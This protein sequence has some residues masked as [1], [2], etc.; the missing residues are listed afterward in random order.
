MERPALLV[1]GGAGT[2]PDELVDA[3]CAS[4]EA[5]A[6]AGWLVL[7]NGGSALDAVEAAVQIMEDDPAPDAGR[8]SHLNRDG[9][10]EMDAIIMDGASLNAG[11]VAGITRVRHPISLARRVM[12]ETDHIMIVG[13]SAERLAREGGLELCPPEWFI[14]QR[15]LD[16]WRQG[17]APYRGK[18]SHGTVGC[19]VRDTHGNLAV[20]TSTGG[21]AGKLPGR[22]GD[23]PLIGCGGYADKRSAAVSATGWGESLMRVI[24]S[25][26]TCDLVAG[27]MSAQ[28][29]ADA[30]V[31]LL[32]ERVDGRGGVIVVD[33]YGQLGM[34]FNTPQMARAWVDRDGK[35]QSAIDPT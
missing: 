30:A 5:A 33:R 29:A 13:D 8:G 9:Q 2:I 31:K 4:C 23:S 28:E 6:A 18:E 25:K 19:V 21:T 22:I 17:K 20:G 10:V 27:G 26:T 3:Y 16:N 35:I 1:H 11:S 7:Q 32:V 34:A 12:E 24:M 15:E 14:V